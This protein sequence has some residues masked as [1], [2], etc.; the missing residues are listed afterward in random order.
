MP[1][2]P[3]QW[4]LVIAL[5]G[6]FPSSAA[7]AQDG[8]RRIPLV[9]GLVLGSVLHSPRAEREDVLE[10]A[11]A[12]TSGVHYAWHERTVTAEG[13]TTSGFRKRFVRANDLAGAPRF[14]DIFGKDEVDRP[15]FTALSVSSA[16]YRQL[17]EVG[18][19][20]FSMMVGPQSVSAAD[21]T[22][23]AFGAMFGQQRTR[24]KGTLKRVS[25]NPEPFSLIV[26]GE[27]AAVPALHLHGDFANGLKRSD[28]E[29]WVLADSAHPL[30]LKSVFGEDVFQMVR[31]DFPVEPPAGKG[32]PPEGH[33]MLPAGEGTPPERQA[34]IRQLKERCRLELPGI[35]FAFGTAAIDPISDRALS[36]LAR[37]LAQHPEWTFTVEG[38]TD[39]VGTAAA[40][41]ALSRRRAEAVRARLAERHGV[42]T[43][44]W[45]A[46]G[47][48]ATRPKESNATI[49]GRARNRRVELVRGCH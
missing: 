46:V 34:M 37:I 7:R 16:V 2:T 22:P 48:G 42:D 12:D 35:Y 17:R 9:Q 24:Y 31:A 20:P 30:L 19:T 11:S 36:E 23:A 28:W 39:S 4:S 32:A 13:D 47:Y 29:L 15:G 38:H 14:D 1:V 49:E 44:A 5:V 40:N 33:A 43:H 10:I 25:A 6:T 27:R 8:A 26:N 41:Q 18:S 45:G 3:R 21:R